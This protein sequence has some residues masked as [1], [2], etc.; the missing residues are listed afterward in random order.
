M[1]DALKKLDK[2]FLVIAGCLIILPII[3]IIFLA[4]IQS[5]GNRKLTYDKYENKMLSAAEKY[6]KAKDSIPTKEGDTKTVKLETLVEESYIKST[7]KLLSDDSCSGSVTVRRN[8]SLIEQ[9]GEGFLNYTYTLNCSDYKTNTLKEMIMN[10]ITTSGDGV[11]EQNGMYIY[12]GEEPK[13]YISLNGKIYRILSVDSEGFAKLIKE[14]S[15]DSEQSWD[16]KYNTETNMST[17]KNIYADSNILKKLLKDYNNPKI[18]SDKVKKVIVSKD[19]CIT[20]RDINDNSFYSDKDCSLKLEKQAVSLINITDFASASRD[21]ECVNIYS[22]SCRN[23][24]YLYKMSLNTWTL[25]PVSGN[26]Y[27]AYY[28]Q[29]SNVDYGD[30]NIYNGYNL[31]IYIDIN[32]KIKSGDGSQKS[33]YTI[34]SVDF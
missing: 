19:V 20:P 14:E 15:G 34:K 33:P 8:G 17:G 6:F 5:C 1:V 28:L 21:T 13:N 27:Q 32:E 26:S 10:D 11:Y 31:V 29:I 16:T 30:T 24:N 7:E 25:T 12:K 23:Y 9:N 3:L 2:K 18:I 4:I 22:K